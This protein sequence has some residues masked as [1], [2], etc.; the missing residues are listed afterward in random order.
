MERFAGESS[1]TA[2][3][4]TQSAPTPAALSASLGCSVL[5]TASRHARPELLEACLHGLGRVA[6]VHRET[7]EQRPE[8]RPWGA[9]LEA[10]DVFVMIGLGETTLAELAAT[11]K[12]VFLAPRRDG[13]R[14]A[15]SVLRDGVLDWI[16]ERAQARPENDRGTVRP[17]EGLELISARLIERGWVRPRRDAEGLRGRL[18]RAGHAR[19]LRAPIRAHDLEGFVS[20]PQSEIPFVADRIRALLG[21]KPSA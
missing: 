2:S 20:P 21:V 14:S 18:V 11:G 15:W 5:V 8:E 4:T 3:K 19:L 13:H 7:A 9:L 17:Q 6:L 12:P 10:G 1:P 16:A